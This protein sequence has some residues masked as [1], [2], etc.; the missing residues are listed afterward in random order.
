MKDLHP[1]LRRPLSA[2]AQ[3]TLAY[4]IRLRR[5]GELAPPTIRELARETSMLEAT[6]RTAAEEL[7]ERRLVVV[8]VPGT[9]APICW[10]R[11]ASIKGRRFAMRLADQLQTAGV[12]VPAQVADRWEEAEELGDWEGMEDRFGGAEGPLGQ[13]GRA[14]V[15]AHKGELGESLELCRRVAAATVETALVPLLARMSGWLDRMLTAAGDPAAPAVAHALPSS[16]N[17]EAERFFH[18]AWHAEVLRNREAAASGYVKALRAD[19]GYDRARIRYARVLYEMGHTEQSLSELKRLA[20]A[21]PGLAAAHLVRAELMIELAQAGSPPPSWAEE[22]AEHLRM[23][24]QCR[25]AN[26][27]AVH[28]LRARL[29]LLTGDPA[30]AAEAARAAIAAQPGDA[31]GY[32]VLGNALAADGEITP[33]A[34]AQASALLCDHEHSQA[35]QA[36]FALRQVPGLAAEVPHARQ[37]IDETWQ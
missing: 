22:T 31:E 12:T 23:A 11:L 34:W 19:P 15:L 33:A 27:G 8:A 2:E 21:R 7:H 4:L 32:H 28:C 35:A 16:E 26:M 13:M 17:E 6:V 18:Q 1:F 36:L 24:E 5:G 25:N 3:A 37:L 30:G 10:P 9:V 20:T 29:R 14:L